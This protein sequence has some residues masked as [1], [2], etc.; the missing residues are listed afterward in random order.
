VDIVVGFGNGSHGG[1]TTA[2][3]ICIRTA[4]GTIYDAAAQFSVAANPAGPWSYG[5]LAPGATP[6]PDTLTLFESA[7]TLGGGP[8]VGAVSNPGTSTWQDLLRDQHPYQHVPHTAA[9]VA[10]L[11]GMTGGGLPL[12]ISEY[13]VGSAVDLWRTTRHYERYGKTEAEDAQ[14]YR[15]WLERFLVDWERWRLAEC[16]TGPDEFFLESQRR[17]ARERLFG[18][19]AIR[20]NPNVIGHSLTGTVDQ[21]MSGEGLFTTFRELKPGTTDALFEALA[22][23]RLCLFATP[24]NLRRGGRVRLEAVLANED[25]L[26]PG[27]YPVRVQLIGPGMNRVL[28][29]VVQVTIPASEPGAE[30]PLALPFFVE[31]LEVNAPAGHYRFLATMERGGAPT[32]GSADVFVEDPGTWP[33]VSAEIVLWGEDEELARWL[34][35]QGLRWRPFAAGPQTTREVILVSARPAPGGAA[36]W[37]ELAAHLA[38]GSVAVFL[39][40]EVFRQGDQPTAWLPLRNKGTLAALRSWLYHKDEW[41]KPHAAFA[42]LSGGGMLDYALYREI[43]PDLAFVGQDA[44]AEAIA[45]GNDGS[46]DYAAGLFLAAY[47]FGAGRVLLNTLLLRER[48]AANPVAERLVRN[49]LNDAASRTTAAPAELPADFAA[50]LQAIGYR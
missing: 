43:L 18:L 37:A 34:T 27:D 20:A 11:R 22:P 47:D 6:D 31:E 41:A 35:G 13:G 14:L 12:F 48:L 30:P 44:P 36:A 46:C 7:E 49:L 50:Q 1:D 29:R 10:V 2:A 26:R 9:T 32:G 23:L 16:F 25:A 42:G 28:D 5:R 19:N 17:M 45:G 4:A 21:G 8:A 39:A 33:P 38:R 3:A 24:S 40:A 15:A